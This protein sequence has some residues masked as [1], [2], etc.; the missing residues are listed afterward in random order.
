[1]Y[2]KPEES[3][4]CLAILKTMFRYFRSHLFVTALAVLA[5]LY[6]LHLIWSAVTH[7]PL[8]GTTT[9][10][11]EVGDVEEIVSVSGLMRA[12]STAELAFPS[13]GVVSKVYVKEGATVKEGDVLATVGAETLV[14][15]R[16]SA[17]A[18]L[19]LAEADRDELVAGARVEA[20]AVTDTTVAIAAAELNRVQE[21]QDLAVANAR[22]TLLSSG[23]IARSEN[24]NE[25]AVAPVISGTY[26]C[27]NAGSYELS[28]FSS[29]SASGYSLNLSGLGSGTYTVGTEQP[30]VF[31]DCGLF[32]LFDGDSNYSGSVWNVEIPNQSSVTYVSNQNAYEAALT[33]RA[34]AVAAATEALALARSKQEL[35]NADPRQEALARAEAKVAGANARIARIDAELGDRAIVAPFDGTVTLVDILPGETAGTAPVFTVLATDAFEL[36]ARIP[37]VDITKLSIG[38]NA[39]VVFD[40]RNDLTLDATVAYVSLL[41]AQI[42]GVA[43]FEVKLEL[44]EPPTWLRGGLNADIDIIIAKSSGVLRVPKRY[45]VREGDTDT[46]L[47]LQGSLIEP[48]PVTVTF[49]GNDGYV[50]IEGLSVDTILI[51]P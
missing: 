31:G 8:E 9:T 49:I 15:E 46:V 30:A 40:A 34:N 48:T 29:R 37:E 5:I 1:M 17:L 44:L 2:A 22:R 4:C 32:A 51:A 13:P 43:Y 36:V 23:L 47:T 14:A 10:T 39:R 18:E 16:A 7:D 27:E 24:V 35:E 50:A 28:L 38:Q 42:D 21:A 19:R 26:R 25:D 11:V 45:I 41:P 6:A 12:R 20:Q 33:A 3:G